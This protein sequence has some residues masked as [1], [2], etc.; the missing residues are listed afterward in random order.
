MQF[1]PLIRIQTQ[2][3]PRYKNGVP[4]NVD[5]EVV[6]VGADFAFLMPMYQ[7]GKAEIAENICGVQR[8]FLKFPEDKYGKVQKV[9]QAMLGKKGGA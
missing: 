6:D 5:A 4:D 1:L 7:I 9:G 8:T 3:N 2:L